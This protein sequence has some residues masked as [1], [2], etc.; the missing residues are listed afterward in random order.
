MNL[1]HGF[2]ARPRLPHRPFRQ[3]SAATNLKCSSQRTG[4]AD[5]GSGH[6]VQ[7]DP[8]FCEE[9]ARR[10]D[11]D[12]RWVSV[13]VVALPL[14]RYTDCSVAEGLPQAKCWNPLSAVCGDRHDCYF[15][16]P[17]GLEDGAVRCGPVPLL[18]RAAYSPEGRCL[19]EM[20]SLFALLSP[21]FSCGGWRPSRI[22]AASSR[23]I[24]SSRL[25]TVM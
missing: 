25:L 21:G 9:Q 10:T 23:S 19:R 16:M 2:E 20:N 11:D 18:H 4:R 8:E 1:R 24:C 14:L 15:R 7:N 22:M 3:V 6:L 17:D 5:R 12:L 13:F